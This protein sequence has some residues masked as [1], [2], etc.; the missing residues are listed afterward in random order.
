LKFAHADLSASSCF[1]EAFTR[2]SLAG[3]CIANELLNIANR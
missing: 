2:G 1:E 3:E